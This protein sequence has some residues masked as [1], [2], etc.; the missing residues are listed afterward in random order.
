MI[1]IV[2][3]KY[4]KVMILKTNIKIVYI[5]LTIRLHEMY[6]EIR[7]VHTAFNVHFT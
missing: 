4:A 1:L 2:T 5:S 6:L 3:K 7:V